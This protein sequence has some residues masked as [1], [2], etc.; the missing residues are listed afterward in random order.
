ME[1]ERMFDF[2]KF[3]GGS[4]MAKLNQ[5]VNEVVENIYDPNTDAKKTRKLTLTLTF[6]PSENRNLASISIQAKASL[7][8]AMPTTTNIMIDKDMNT[9]EVVASE[10]KNKLPGQMEINT[11]DPEQPEVKNDANVI[12][13]KKANTNK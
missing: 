10:L 8:P 6:K 7:Q 3:A 12:D 2:E 9:G 1:N 13:L 4:L 5:E 11:D